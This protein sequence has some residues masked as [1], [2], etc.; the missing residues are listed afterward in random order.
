M[1]LKGLGKNTLEIV[2]ISINGIWILV[3]GNE[4]FLSYESN[5]WFKDATVSQ[6][7]NV[8][9]L[10][11]FHLRWDDLDVDLELDSLINPEKYPLTAK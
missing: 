6:I 2:N 1:K 9:L 11:G 4:Y 3:K 5:P 8:K 7:H 10:H